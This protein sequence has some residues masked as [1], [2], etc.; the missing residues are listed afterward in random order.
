[1]VTICLP[2]DWHASVRHG[3]GR[4]VFV[5][6]V[7]SRK[8]TTPIREYV[9]DLNTRLNSSTPS[10]QFCRRLRTV[11]LAAVSRHIRTGPDADIQSKRLLYLNRLTPRLVGPSN[12]QCSGGIHGSFNVGKVG[13]GRLGV[14][15]VIA[16]QVQV[17][18]HLHRSHAL[19][20]RGQLI[21]RQFQI[22][23]DLVS[24]R[25]TRQN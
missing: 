24:T 13:L 19:R 21:V 7:G 9:T 16:R 14:G 1:M 11:K 8:H 25:V 4:R 2:T 20:K 10:R 3:I 18:T 22:P 15:K 17:P 23:T 12:V 6:N 5:E